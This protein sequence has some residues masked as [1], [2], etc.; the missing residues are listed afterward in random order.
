MTALV[1]GKTLKGNWHVLDEI[2]SSTYTAT[3]DLRNWIEK[4]H[5]SGL[6]K[7]DRQMTFVNSKQYEEFAVCV[8]AGF[9]V[10]AIPSITVE[11]VYPEGND[12]GGDE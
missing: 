5:T 1:V 9:S 7:V 2:D 3:S 8:K 6:I 11:T 4:M 12:A 10:K